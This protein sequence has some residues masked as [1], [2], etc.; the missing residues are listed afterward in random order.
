MNRVFDSQFQRDRLI[1]SPG[2]HAVSEE[3]VVLY[4]VLG[5]CVA[6]CLRDS[7]R[8]IS[9]MNHFMLPMPLPSSKFF[10]SDAGRFGLQAMEL[11]I[12]GML[13]RGATRPRLRAKVFGGGHVL[14]TGSRADKVPSSNCAFALEY[15]AAEGIPVLAQD[16]GGLR[17]RK[18]S[19]LARTFEVLVHKLGAHHPPEVIAEERAYRTSLG[20]ETRREHRVSQFLFDEPAPAV[21]APV[22]DRSP[23]S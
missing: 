5:S 12:N 18:V 13:K 14:S 3:D 8:G 22:S 17:A 4:T 10:S 6:V 2:E 9:G 21:A 1:L 15:L 23:R 19:F 20:A 16:L 11:V 7:I